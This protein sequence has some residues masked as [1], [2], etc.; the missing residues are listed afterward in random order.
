MVK[1]IE[2]GK[3][4]TKAYPL[5]T[6]CIILAGGKGLRLGHDKVT[7]TVGNSS[8][9]QNVI[10]RVSP[11]CQDIVVVAAREQNVPLLGSAPKARVVT[12]VF[13]DMGPL[14]GIY[15][16]LKA[17]GS[18]Y[19]IVVA[20]DMPFLNIALLGYMA[21]LAT[22]FDMVVPRLGVFTEPLHSVYTA[23]CLA[24]AENLLK[25]GQLSVNRLLGMVRVRY[26]AEEEIDRFDPQHRSFF[27]INT[28]ADLERA[29]EMASREEEQ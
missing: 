21:Q 16:G 3:V 22:G 18:F 23:E 15:T 1:F 25:Q 19:N 2:G 6:S 29:R 4:L 9:L 8:L 26:V 14:G 27:N 10:S 5:A 20:S 28:R 11:L 12:D 13:P 7:V 24:P 17:S